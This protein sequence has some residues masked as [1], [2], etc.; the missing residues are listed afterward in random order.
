ML[1]QKGSMIF[2]PTFRYVAIGFAC[3]VFLFL[4]RTPSHTAFSLLQFFVARP[5]RRSFPLEDVQ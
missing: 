5:K 1:H 2:L 3:T 4:V